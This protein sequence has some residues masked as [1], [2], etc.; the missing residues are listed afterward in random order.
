[1]C[2]HPSARSAVAGLIA[3]AAPAQA[4]PLATFSFGTGVPVPT[5]GLCWLMPGSEQRTNQI[6]SAERSFFAEPRTLLLP[7]DTRRTGTVRG[8]L[9]RR[10][11]RDRTA[12]APH[13]PAVRNRCT[14]TADE[15]RYTTLENVAV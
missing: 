3:V 7:T 8:P 12:V 14:R 6:P 4:W 15:H 11:V 9:P 1:M 2:R 5:A 10:F 13:S